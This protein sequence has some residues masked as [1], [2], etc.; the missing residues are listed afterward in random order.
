VS[1]VVVLCYHAVSE[2]FPAALSVTPERFERQLARLR[3]WGF[4]GATFTEAVEAPPARRTVAITF[5][6]A[7][8]SV[9]TRALPILAAAGFPATV[10]APT[11]HIGTERPMAWPGIDQWLD[12]PHEAELMPASWDELALLAGEGWEI[13]SH[14]C[15]HPRLTRLGDEELARELEVSR[16]A[17][18]EKLGECPSIAYPY[19]DA[20]GRVVEA[21]RSAGYA[22]AAALPGPARRPSPALDWPRVGVYRQDADWRFVLKAAPW[23]RRMRIGGARRALAGVAQR[24]R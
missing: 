5:D 24:V 4:E 13:G 2:D 14:T 19:G 10:F 9:V 6:D 11:D 1:D 18:T 17:I 7:Y 22:T 16:A 12:G 23:A 15:S 8:R 21:A 20:D 3:A